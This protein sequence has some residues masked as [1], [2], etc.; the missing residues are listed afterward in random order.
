MS[1]L[2]VEVKA[3]VEHLYDKLAF[4]RL[5]EAETLSV[6]QDTLVRVIN[7]IYEKMARVYATGE[8]DQ[9]RP[10]RTSRPKSSTSRSCSMTTC[11]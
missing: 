2:L 10:I 3:G 6:S 5:E 9:S 4:Y 11:C 1:K 7:H 8:N